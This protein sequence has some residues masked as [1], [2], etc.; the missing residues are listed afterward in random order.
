MIPVRLEL[1]NFLPYRS[2]D[3]IFFEGIHLAALIGQNGSGKS[4][5]LD[6]ITWALW[7][8]ARARRDDD[9]VHLGQ[10]EM[11]IQLDF[12]QEGTTYR[13]VRRRKTGK[14]GQGQ[15]DLFILQDDEQP[16]TINEPSM[17]ATQSKIDEILRLDYETFINSAFLQQGKADA[18]TTKTPAE[19]KKIL[20]DILGLE[21]WSVYE[22][23][24]K[25]K[26]KDL[27]R[28]VASI[29]GAL[30]TI[31]EELAKA[32]QYKR[33]LE[34]AETAY[35]LA[36][37]ALK[38]A[39]ARVEE[40][41]DVPADLR[42]AQNQQADIN[43]RIANF[44]SDLASVEKEIKK[45]KETISQYEAVLEHGE[46]IEEGYQ[47]LQHARE[48]D[49]ELGAKL[50]DMSD[51]DQRFNDVQSQLKDAKNQIEQE[52]RGFEITIIEMQRVLEQNIDDELTQVQAD[53][54]ALETVEKEREAFQA[55]LANIREERS[56]LSTRKKTL[57]TE[58]QE[59]NERI[60]TLEQAEGASCPLCGQALNDDHREAILA[61]LTLERDTKREEYRQA[62][63][64][65]ADIGK[66]TKLIQADIETLG[67]Q[68]A[69]L[70]KLRSRIGALEKQ[71][72]DRLIAQARV[73]EANAGLQSIITILETDDYAHEIRQQL[74]EVT[75]EREAIGYDRSAHDEAQSTLKE[76]TAYEAQFR[77]LEFARK[78]LPSEIEALEGVEERKRRIE[79]AFSEEAEALNALKE[80][81]EHL[82]LM[83]VEYEKRTREVAAAKTTEQQ[84]YG[85]VSAANQQL[86]ALESSRKRK[87]ELEERRES[88]RDEQVI[89]KE[90]Q[91][92]FGKNGI[93]AMI[94][95]A[96]T[97]ELETAANEL[98]GR[99]TDGRMHLTFNTQRAKA[100][101]SGTIETLDID[102]A[103]EL[104]TRPYEMY[105]GGEAFR[106]NFAIRVAL[107]K[108]LA[109]RA[110][111]HL[112]T[113]FIDEGFGT[114]D[115]DGRNKLVEAI[116]AI[117]SEF[118]LIMVIT[119]IDELRD[120]F[121]VHV[122]VEK[123]ANGSMISLR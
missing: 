102:I 2:P 46:S 83:K 8:R 4:S 78:T 66:E 107:S 62:S 91:M 82:T 12:E 123:T 75:A 40:V 22:D 120:A 86:K 64:R 55:S 79:T 81:I 84:T 111:A 114:Q 105:S 35:N 80:D 71:A 92:A 112:R 34:T 30:S 106:V 37:E 59:M 85:R 53:I 25:V 17:R 48:A 77:D 38:D 103:D 15:L 5:L 10:T 117:Q 32:P 31:E 69:D 57:T 44:E 43:R 74:A 98:L 23:R 27:D 110:G 45:R 21:Q 73:D 56:G 68:L 49:S 52:K 61:D 99:M 67:V 14:R 113:L 41:K 39:E 9:L 72:E 87:Q 26:L 50:R 11:Y 3:P 118:D 16:R 13:V 60:E 29:D 116:T 121:P 88:T 95:E 42:N 109:R 54:S 47:T 122:M 7:G 33:E 100:S 1:H 96:A 70:P 76:F 19:R 36:R 63:E 90:L 104:G 28:A 6:A 93:P 119:H 65:I 108:M 89:Y 58:G 97:P 18:F 51:L 115:D 20:S 24:V 101:G 94:I